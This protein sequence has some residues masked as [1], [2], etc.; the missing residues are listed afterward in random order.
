MVI[1]WNDVAFN[2]ESVWIFVSFFS[3]FFFVGALYVI[4]VVHTLNTWEHAHV[5]SYIKEPRRKKSTNV[6]RNTRVTFIM[7]GQISKHKHVTTMAH[8]NGKDCMKAKREICVY[9]LSVGGM[10]KSE[11]VHM[12]CVGQ[13]WR[14]QI[15]DFVLIWCKRMR[16]EKIIFVYILW[17]HVFLLYCVLYQSE[18]NGAQYKNTQ[19]PAYTST[20]PNMY[21]IWTEY[22]DIIYW[23]QWWKHVAHLLFTPFVYYIFTTMS[24]DCVSTKQLNCLRQS[25]TK[26]ICL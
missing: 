17:F 2:F 26:V 24:F 7:T 13:W 1:K 9:A 16:A 3:Y 12:V 23:Q 15:K 8:K 4:S 14:G 11:C 20:V 6:Q 10:G 25:R 22:T 5:N 21:L 19:T 18:A